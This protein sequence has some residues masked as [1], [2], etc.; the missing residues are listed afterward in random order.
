MSATAF[1]DI[2]ALQHNYT[3]LSR[4]LGRIAC[5]V[6]AD[7]YGHGAEECASALAEC[8][9][10]FFAVANLNEALKLEAVLRANGHLRSDILILGYTSLDDAAILEEKRFIQTVYSSD[11]GKILKDTERRLRTHIKL[12]I[13]MNRLGFRLSKGSG[14]NA[15]FDLLAA[16]D[17]KHIYSNSRLTAE[18]IFTHLPCADADTLQARKQTKAQFSAFLSAIKEL[19]R[20]DICPRL[21]HACNTAAALLYPEMRLDMCRV[22]LALYGMLPSESIHFP[23]LLP[24]MSFQAPIIHIHTA[25][26]GESVGYG[27][28]YTC[29]KRTVIATVSAGYADGFLRRYAKFASPI[30]LNS[31][32]PVKVIGN[33]C[34]DQL[35]LDVTAVT[36]RGCEV[37]VGD[38]VE[39]FSASAPSLS[40]SISSLAHLSGTIPYEITASLPSRVSREYIR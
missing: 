35:M 27:A 34:M 37:K 26:R 13:G 18:G 3:V 25:N 12:D 6:K 21:K 29:N 40:S 24:V 19:E 36:E 28:S 2:N 22:G 7:A 14:A 8:G 4:A 38:K 33:V 39:L 10:S 32:H 23:Q 15:E 30:L 20:I 17:I 1:I 5:V 9:A 31:G 16:E 11:Y